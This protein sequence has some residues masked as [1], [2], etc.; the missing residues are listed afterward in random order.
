MSQQ[1]GPPRQVIQ[2][3]ESKGP[4]AQTGNFQAVGVITD[5]LKSS[6]GSMGMDKMLVDS[7]GDAIIT[8]DGATILKELDIDHPAARIVIDASAATDAKVGDGTTSTALLIGSIM[9]E[10]KKLIEK[11]IHP[12]IIVRTLREISQ[13]LIK[14]LEPLALDVNL[15]DRE[16]VDKIITTVLASKVVATDTDILKDLIIDA[17]GMVRG[18][19]VDLSTIKIEK[20]LGGSI[21]DSTL[22]Q[23]IVLDKGT[24]HNNMPKRISDAKIAIINDVL[25]V[26]RTENS[27]QVNV[28]SDEM[29]NINDNETKYLKEMA[30]KIT[31]LG[32]NVVFCQRGIDDIVQ[33]YLEKAGIIAIKRVREQDIVN[34]SK[35]TGAKIVNAFDDLSEGDLG[36]AGVVHEEISD[37]GGKLLFVEECKNSTAVTILLRGGNQQIIDEMERSLHD[38]IMVMKD[39]IEV[40]KIVVGAGAP[41]IS[42]SR[43]IWAWG[44]SNL[45]G[46][47][48]L[49]AKAVADAL[50]ELPLTLAKNA[51]LDPIDTEI[52]LRETKKNDAGVGVD[53]DRGVIDIVCDVYEPLVVKKQ[54][55]TGAIEAACM[56]LRI[57]HILASNKQPAPQ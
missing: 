4:Y 53:P 48:R 50:L 45:P 39:I 6:F 57:D 49:V 51:G 26:K 32:A 52:D 7:L 22:I 24:A 25:E 28:T 46:K 47:K 1:Q 44:V 31:A 27:A 18:D 15:N 37:A 10:A 14:Q 36:H 30:E 19:G 13:E 54:V 40:P 12:N 21:R 23:G 2:A 35:S 55:I 16:L 29:F 41:E 20:Q 38:A 11:D 8:N 3:N 56:I 5:V 42:L 33:H 17:V 34:L 9:A 43:T